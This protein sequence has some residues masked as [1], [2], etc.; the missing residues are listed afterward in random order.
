MRLDHLL[1]REFRNIERA[2]V[3]LGPGV[4]LLCGANAQGK[5][6]LLEAVHLLVT[7]RSFRARRERECIRWRPSAPPGSEGRTDDEEDRAALVRG[8]II[9]ASGQHTVQVALQGQHRRIEIDGAP[10]TKLASLWGRINAVLFTPDDLQLIK[11]PPA[12]RRLLLDT[13]ISQMRPA[14]LLWLQRFQTALRE[15][16]ALLRAVAAGQRPRH[17][18]DAWDA[19]LAEA[20]AE[21][22]GHRRDIVGRLGP[23]VQA[24]HHAISGRSETLQLVHHS[25]LETAGDLTREESIDRHRRLLLEAREAD[26]ERG[27]TTVGPHRDDLWIFID[28]ADARAFASQGQQRA[29]I[30]ALRMAEVTLMEEETGETPLLLLDDIVSELDPERRRRFFGLLRPEVQTLVT[31]VETP[32]ALEGVTPS[33]VFAVR[34]GLVAPMEIHEVALAA[35]P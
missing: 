24:T 28:G 29:V 10:I 4:N 14:Y 9:R 27:Q 31:T 17:E 1:I 25:Q 18:L 23:L 12:M 35:E 13:E 19:T 7:G 21:I 2:E 34:R 8:Q 33:R 15:R 11:G 26:I 3:E 6:N 22:H 32:A 16:A 20:S 30:L 5:T